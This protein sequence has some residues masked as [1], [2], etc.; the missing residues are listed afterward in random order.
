MKTYAWI[1]ML[2]CVGL[3]LAGCGSKEPPAPAPSPDVPDVELPDEPSPPPAAPSFED[4]LDEPPMTPIE[5]A[6]GPDLGA[7]AEP[8]PAEPAMD[9]PA[10]D[11]S[12]ATEGGSPGVTRAFGAALLKGITD[13]ATGNP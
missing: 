12:A 3:M 5:P 13:G 1:A 9:E 4:D 8:A 6:T 2:L 11:D 7:P 10:T